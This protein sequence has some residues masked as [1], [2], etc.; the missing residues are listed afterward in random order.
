MRGECVAMIGPNGAGKTTLLRLLGQDAADEGTI[1]LGTNLQTAVFD[2][3]RA[4][5]DPNASRC[6]KT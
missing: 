6:G 3:T 5:L 4:Q 1:R 2:Q